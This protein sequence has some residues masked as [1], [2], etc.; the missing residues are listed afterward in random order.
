[1]SSLG[2]FFQRFWLPGAR[3]RPHAGSAADAARFRM[4][5]WVFLALGGLFLVQVLRRGHRQAWTDVFVG[6]VVSLVLTAT[7]LFEVLRLLSY[8]LALLGLCR[9]KLHPPGSG[10]RKQRRVVVFDG[11]CVLCNKFGQFVYWRLLETSAVDF[12]PFQ[13]MTNEHVNLDALVKEFGFKTEQLKDRI[14][15][16]SGKRI[17]WGPDAVIE[18]MQ[19]CKWPYPLASLGLLIPRAFRDALYMTV[20][21]NRYQY[22]GTQ[23]LEDNFAKYLCPYY[24]INKKAFDK[25]DKEKKKS[26]AGSG[27]AGSAAGSAH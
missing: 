21:K 3:S 10:P 12:V 9:R 23:P 8:P 17:F 22:F 14:C 13:D 18:I 5:L 2:R 19:W 15:V 4:L 7:L 6:T 25:L 1:M 11:I 24:Y 20:A 16:V 27:R 26:A